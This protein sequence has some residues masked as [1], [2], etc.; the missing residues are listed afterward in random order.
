[1]RD[2]ENF[3]GQWRTA[4]DEP[5]VPD[6]PN[7]ALCSNRFGELSA[8]LRTPRLPSNRGHWRGIN[9]EAQ[10]G[11]RHDAN[12]RRS[13][14]EDGC[15]KVIGEMAERCNPPWES[16]FDYAVMAAGTRRAHRA[17]RL[18]SQR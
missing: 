2:P 13:G 4:R 14:C 9:D 5:G 1:M 7:F 16:G 15:G 3:A 6:V 17:P 18:Q 12:T 11:L 10:G 8:R